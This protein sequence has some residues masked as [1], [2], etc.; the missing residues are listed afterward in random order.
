[1]QGNVAYLLACLPICIARL[2]CPAVYG[3]D[4]RRLAL[5][6]EDAEAADASQLHRLWEGQAQQAQQKTAAAVQEEGHQQQQRQQQQQVEQQQPP[7]KRELGQPQA[8]DSQHKELSADEQVV[9]DWM[10]AVVR[11]GSQQAAAAAAGEGAEQQQQPQSR[12]SSSRKLKQQPLG[13]PPCALPLLACLL[14]PL[15]EK[16]R[17]PACAARPAEC[18]AERGRP[19]DRPTACLRAPSHALRPPCPLCP[20]CSGGRDDGA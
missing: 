2:Y 7:R 17:F 3:G 12:R 14:C 5:L 6:G 1:M 4:L 15:L 20:L 18:P 10:E 13:A 9:A 8:T 11:R 19:A 16:N